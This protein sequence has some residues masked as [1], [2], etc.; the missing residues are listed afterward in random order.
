MPAT[1][2][3]VMSFPYRFT[4]EVTNQYVW[5]RRFIDQLSPLAKHHNGESGEEDYE[6]N[7]AYK[8]RSL[9]AALGMVR[10][11]SPAPGTAQTTGL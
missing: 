5:R 2:L 7:G 1:M 10:G 8:Q 3:T 11:T 6:G 9:D 4:V